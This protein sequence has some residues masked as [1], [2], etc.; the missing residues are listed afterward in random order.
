MAKKVKGDLEV[1]RNITVHGQNPVKSLNNNYFVDDETADLDF[2]VPDD[3]KKMLEILPISRVG[4][5]NSLPMAVTDKFEGAT[6]SDV[7]ASAGIL[8]N[9]GTFIYFRPGTSGSTLGLY[10]NYVQNLRGATTLTP[11]QTTSRYQPA[12]IPAGLRP[13]TIISTDGSVLVGLL[14]NESD[15]SITPTQMFVSITNNTMLQEQHTGTVINVSLFNKYPKYTMSCGN[16]VYFISD[17]EH[18][19]AGFG[20][21]IY[22]MLKSDII[23][24]TSTSFERMT[25]WNSTGFYN[26]TDTN[27][28]IASVQKSTTAADKPYYLCN[29]NAL[30]INYATNYWVS[31][32]GAPSED[33]SKFRLQYFLHQYCNNLS[34]G[35]ETVF[36]TTFSVVI[37]PSAKTAT[38]DSNYTNT[39]GSP[40][41]INYDGN[42]NLTVTSSLSSQAQRVDGF[43][44]A[45]ASYPSQ[46][47]TN[48]NLSI[49]VRNSIGATGTHTIIRSQLDS[50]KSKYDV[51]NIKASAPL[52]NVLST[53]CT[54]IYGS[55]IG[56]NPLGLQPLGNNKFLA[57]SLVRTYDQAQAQANWTQ[58][59]VT[60]TPPPNYTYSSVVNGTYTGYMPSTDRVALTA[61]DNSFFQIS[62][63]IDASE[64]VSMYG[65]HL[66]YD[67]LSNFYT[68]DSNLNK[69]GSVTITQTILDNIASQVVT[70]SGITDISTSRKAEIYATKITDNTIP[71]IIIVTTV[72]NSTKKVNYIFAKCNLTSTGTAPNFNITGITNLSIIQ[73]TS[74]FDANA[75]NNYLTNTERYRQSQTTGCT[76]KDYGTHY[77]YSVTGA[78]Q[79]SVIGNTLSGAAS[80]LIN[81]STGAASN[82][83]FGNTFYASVSPTYYQ[84]TYV[85]NVGFGNIQLGY[86]ESD[87]ST[88][89]IFQLRARTV[90]EYQSWASSPG[91]TNN[92]SLISNTVITSQDLAQGYIVYFTDPVPVIVNGKYYI[93]NPTSIDLRDI[94]ANP[95]STKFYIYV[96]VIN[97]AAKFTISETELSE[98]LFRIYIGTVTTD[99]N[100]ISVIVVN[101]VSRIDNLR[102]SIQPIGS[103]IPVSV[104]TVNSTGTMNWDL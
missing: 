93:I 42:L 26:I 32:Q 9:D 78:I 50:T 21:E 43:V 88:K 103:G 35:F 84:P 54:S 12:Y 96:E 16:Y 19:S 90:A 45:L 37:D 73:N 10:Y 57:S 49:S 36:G 60:V 15:Y 30:A 14:Y 87:Y 72:N 1:K 101:K 83:V 23:A 11:V 91:F 97:N 68:C 4:Q 59:K 40:V 75:T 74:S 77:L 55:V 3:I 82:Y 95:S 99:A 5:L 34:S 98:E 28:K 22:R 51:M 25:N 17:L 13:G 18:I 58:V 41:S 27:V 81:K 92:T 104:G 29:A 65:A 67:R 48:D 39:N 94:K 20:F 53:R 2:F 69:T 100:Q 31:I 79:A 52:T 76:I 66:H 6:W 86:K 7:Q 85:P 46:F 62:S 80:F 63:I 8:E 102:P 56:S 89:M 24:G 38:V 71:T 64:N 70:L 61:N 47:I 44:F 33:G